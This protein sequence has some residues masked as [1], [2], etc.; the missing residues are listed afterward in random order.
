MSKSELPHNKDTHKTIILGVGNELMS[1]EGVGVHVAREMMTRKLP[2]GVEVIEG[3]TDGFGLLNIITDADRL[4]VIDTLKGGSKPGTIYQFHI[5]DAPATSDMFK[6]SIHQIGILEVIHLSGLIG[7][8]PYTTVIGVEP[9]SIAMGM[10]LSDEVRQKVPRV[11]E[12]V[13][14]VV[15]VIKA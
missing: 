1:D 14:K 3:G 4:I 2:A 10:E 11:I 9:G 5:E 8:T 6:T 13:E 12:I 15:S 7:K